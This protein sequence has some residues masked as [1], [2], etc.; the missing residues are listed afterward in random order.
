MEDVMGTVWNPTGHEAEIEAA[1]EV[2]RSFTADLDQGRIPVAT[3]ESV[4]GAANTLCDFGGCP[5]AAF[6]FVEYLSSPQCTSY[7]NVAAWLKDFLPEMSDLITWRLE[8]TAQTSL[9]VRGTQPFV[10]ASDD[11]LPF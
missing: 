7:R 4:T 9:A 3:L 11:D 8:R 2:L 1:K 6:N 10:E 5:V